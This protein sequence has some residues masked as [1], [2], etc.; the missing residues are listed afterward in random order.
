MDDVDVRA[1]QAAII[2]AWQADCNKARNSK[3][4]AAEL[5]AMYHEIDEEAREDFTV[6]TFGEEDPLCEISLN[7]NAGEDLLWRLCC[8]GD[9]N[10]R[11][12]DRLSRCEDVDVRQAV[13]GHQEILPDTMRRLATD[14]HPQVRHEAAV[15]TTDVELLGMMIQ[16]T[17]TT[18]QSAVASNENTRAAA[19]CVLAQNPCT[20]VRRK[21]AANA[22]ADHATLEMLACDLDETVR[23]N[24]FI[25]VSY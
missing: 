18:V 12:N 6:Q 17:S 1:E 7:P 5:L 19:L 13:C 3:T 11:A 22:N 9:E 21:V 10:I 4:T 24:V 20:A 25:N 16:D 23:L 15:H 14:T 8:D 2:D